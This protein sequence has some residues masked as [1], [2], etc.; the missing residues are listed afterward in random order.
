[1]SEAAIRIDRLSV[2]YGSVVALSDVSFSVDDGEYLGIV[3]PNGGGKSTLIKAVLGFVTPSS[4]T[5][6][7]YGERAGHVSASL[8]YVPQSIAF[9]RKFPIT[10]LEVVLMGRLPRT[11]RPFHRFS[12][13]D[14][15]AAHA[16]LER[17]GIEALADRQIAEL[18]GGEFQKTLVA[19][20]LAVNP[21]L[22]LL[23]EP[24]AS[25]DTTS[26]EQIF[27]LLDEL[28]GET[29]IVMV[30]HDLPGVSAHADTLVGLDTH[31]IYHGN[32]QQVGEL[33][34]CHPGAHEE[35]RPSLMM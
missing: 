1:M 9:N 17:V 33:P 12:S 13:A 4:G 26:S 28:R 16:L 35:P 34:T 10:V 20:A 19:R 29:T 23:D 27:N 15:E 14:R 6:T 24:T 25:I 2:N 3:G 11:L 5:V 21:R 8:G 22:L 30:S 31:L 7:I 32:P 18:S